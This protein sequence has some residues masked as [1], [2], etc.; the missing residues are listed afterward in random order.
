[1]EEENKV[2]D[3]KTSGFAIASFVLGILSL[4]FGWSIFFGIIFGIISIILAIVA[5]ACKSKKVFAVIGMV[6]SALGITIAVTMIILFGIIFFHITDENLVN[7]IQQVFEDDMNST[8]VI[9]DI[10]DNS[11]VVGDDSLLTFD[12]STEFKYYKSKTD[13]SDNYYQGT[14]KIYVGDEAVD[15]IANDLSKYGVTKEEQEQILE[16]RKN[17]ENEAYV[18]IVLT[19]KKCIQDGENTLEKTVEAPYYG[20]YDKDKKVLDI[21]NMNTGTTY[22]FTKYSK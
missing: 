5:F 17:N 12:N 18:C 22:Y 9:N 16:T 21:I 11:W 2:V 6:L 3:R 7:A 4:T 13:K 1:M 8:R 14:Y 19:N 20:F 10:K 15:Y